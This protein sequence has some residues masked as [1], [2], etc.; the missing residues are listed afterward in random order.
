MNYR[1]PKLDGALLEMIRERTSIADEDVARAF[2]ASPLFRS[3]YSDLRTCIRALA[4]WERSEAEEAGQRIQE[5]A[6]LVDELVDE[7]RFALSAR[8][9]SP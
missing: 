1:G 7:I 3:L 8:G 9:H 6:Q 2:E 5:Y 4:R